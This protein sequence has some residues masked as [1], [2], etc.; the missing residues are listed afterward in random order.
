MGNLYRFTLEVRQGRLSNAADNLPLQ[1]A[2]GVAFSSV[3]YLSLPWRFFRGDRAFC[4]R[5]TLSRCRCMREMS[6]LYCSS[7]LFLSFT[8]ATI[9]DIPS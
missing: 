9:L 6:W 3:G 7:S 8:I 4:I 1:N 5:H 2:T